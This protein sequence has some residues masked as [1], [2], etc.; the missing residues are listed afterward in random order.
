MNLPDFISKYNRFLTNKKSQTNYKISYVTEYVKNWLYVVCNYPKSKQINFFDCMANAGIY[1]D[2]DFCTSI[3]VFELFLENAKKYPEKE[4][5][6][7]LNDNDSRKT[8]ILDKIIKD[9]FKEI[10]ANLKYYIETND[11]NKYLER[12]IKRKFLNKTINSTIIFVD[13]FNFGTV[14]IPILKKLCQT[15]YCELL[16]NLFTSDWVRNRNNEMDNKIKE[17][18]QNDKVVLNDKED[19]VKY[20]IKELC[21]GNMKHYFNYEFRIENNAELYQIIYFTPNDVGLEKLKDALWKT[22]NGYSFYKN[23]KEQKEG[24][25][26][27]LSEEDDENLIISHN[28]LQAKNLICSQFKGME[29][30]YK[31][32]NNLIL[33]N[34]MLCKR[35]ILN[36]VI[37]P[38]LK[39]GTLIKLGKAGRKNNFTN[40]YYKVGDKIC[41]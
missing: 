11:V 7:F 13:P 37:K 35:H 31:D 24:Q 30:R 38:M 41:S 22:F 25:L 2:G 32:L 39:E 21:V 17:V 3:K 27:F 36:H 5:N 6:I 29:I 12:L 18:I 40:D 4:F 19:L 34:T 1:K 14:K 26:S 16:Y 20:I 9:L 8:T 23:K 28:V 10:P 15:T 33:S